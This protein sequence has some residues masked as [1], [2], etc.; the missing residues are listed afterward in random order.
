MRQ[1]KTYTR[2]FSLFEEGEVYVAMYSEGCKGR[3]LRCVCVWSNEWMQNRWLCPLSDYISTSAHQVKHTSIPNAVFTVLEMEDSNF[4]V[5]TLLEGCD[6]SWA[7]FNQQQQHFSDWTS[8]VFRPLILL[9]INFNF[10]RIYVWFSRNCSLIK[11][12]LSIILPQAFRPLLHKFT[13]YFSNKKN[14]SKL[15]KSHAVCE[16]V[17][18]SPYCF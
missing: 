15:M 3:G 4:F 12:L 16:H 13:A 6:I 11:E 7:R 8:H 1:I 14:K 18:A 9:K 2:H 17:Y 5:T 10:P